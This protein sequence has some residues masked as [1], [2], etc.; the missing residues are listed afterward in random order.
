MLHPIGK[1]LRDSIHL[2]VGES[3]EYGE[4]DWVY[5][6]VSLWSGSPPLSCF[7]W[8]VYVRF[9]FKQHCTLAQ[10]WDQDSGLRACLGGVCRVST[11]RSLPSH[12]HVR[13]PRPH[14]PPPRYRCSNAS[15]DHHFIWRAVHPGY[16]WEVLDFFF[17]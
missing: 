15:S 17:P 1:F 9:G 3:Q 5:L 12:W 7:H 8:Q 2:G 13:L 10:T 6:P 11:A 4:E 14:L 16:L